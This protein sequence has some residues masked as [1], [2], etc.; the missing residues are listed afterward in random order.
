MGNVAPMT[1]NLCLIPVVGGVAIASMKELSFTWTSFG[2]AMGSNLS[3]ALRGIFSK[4][5]MSA[6]VGEHMGPANLFAVLT[7]MSFTSM[8]PVCIFFEGKN[9]SPSLASAYD[10]YGSSDK[11]L[12]EVLFAGLFYYLYNEVAYLALGAVDSP[13]T[14]AVGNT[15][16]RVVVMVASAVYFKDKMTGQAMGG[17]CYCYWRGYDVLTC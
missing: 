7:I 17:V 12:T 2:G 13:T 11:F 10:H 1:V 8:L 14:H 3:F 16:K 4:K 6:P 5:A 9:M 15:L